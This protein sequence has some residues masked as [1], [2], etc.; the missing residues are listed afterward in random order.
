MMNSSCLSKSTRKSVN[1]FIYVH[2]KTLIPRESQA[3]MIQS[4]MRNN[5]GIRDHQRGWW[6][7]YD[8]LKEKV[9]NFLILYFLKIMINTLVRF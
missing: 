4:T 3:I 7:K 1:K 6:F 8:N 5:K 2:F 9:L